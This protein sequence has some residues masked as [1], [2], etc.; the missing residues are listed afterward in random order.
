MNQTCQCENER[1]FGG[2]GHPYMSEE[3]TTTVRTLYGTFH[4]CNDCVRS[5][6]F[7]QGV[8]D[9]WVREVVPMVSA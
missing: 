5:C 7:E 8:A 1:H 6:G 3:A 4:V 2:A 9:G